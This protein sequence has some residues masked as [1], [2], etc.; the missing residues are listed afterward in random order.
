MGALHSRIMVNRMAPANAAK[1]KRLFI[2][3]LIRCCYKS[4][5]ELG[6]A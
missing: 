2:R 6:W 5:T 1:I 4:T 3:F